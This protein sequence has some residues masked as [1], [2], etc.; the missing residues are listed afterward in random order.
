MDA[1][2]REPAQQQQAGPQAPVIG[3]GL[4]SRNLVQPLQMARSNSSASLEAFKKSAEGKEAAAQTPTAATAPQS[5]ARSVTMR[6]EPGIASGSVSPVKGRKLSLQGFIS[7][8]SPRAGTAPK[9]P[10]GS[11]TAVDTPRGSPPREVTASARVGASPK[12]SRSSQAYTPTSLAGPSTVNYLS[13]EAFLD[14][15]STTSAS[16]AID[17]GQAL[18][19]SKARF[20]GL[21]DEFFDKSSSALRRGEIF[22]E[23]VQTYVTPDRLSLLGVVTHSPCAST[24]AENW[25]KL[26]ASGGGESVGL[27]AHGLSSQLLFELRLEVDASCGHAVALDDRQMQVLVQGEGEV[28]EEL[29]TLF[30]RAP[31]EP[32]LQTRVL[33]D[34]VMRTKLHAFLREEYA[35]ENLEFVVLCDMALAQPTPRM[36]AI[37]F[38]PYFSTYLGQSAPKQ[39]NITITQLQSLTAPWT[40][41]QNNTGPAGIAAAQLFRSALQDARGAIQKLMMLDSMIRFGKSLAAKMPP[42]S[43]TDVR[44]TTSQ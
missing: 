16:A 24:L 26:I 19:P 1:P 43:Q 21:C 22:G 11:P 23:I 15:V 39:V 10:A 42:S 36:T 35:P 9:S 2:V 37:A 44:S 33:Q 18:A 7:A 41:L 13:S 32:A 5:P 8:L 27:T 34:P 30:A 6:V 14:D 3:Q 12:P 28:D 29:E 25:K 31:R 17:P 4:R 40:D 38:A 20:L